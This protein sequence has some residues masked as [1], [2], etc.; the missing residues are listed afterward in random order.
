MGALALA[1]HLR[2]D[3]CRLNQ[4]EMDQCCISSESARCIGQALLG[5]P[6][7]EVRALTT[8]AQLVSA[9]GAA[10]GVKHVIL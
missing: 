2:D 1:D 8:K 7:A 3:A 9:A 6:S 4:M 10:V 5:A